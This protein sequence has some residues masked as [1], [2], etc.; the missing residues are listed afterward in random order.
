L[1]ITIMAK[2]IQVFLAHASEDKQRVREL[3]MKLEAKGFKPWLDV[4]DILPGQNWKTEIPK[5]I[6]S[7]DIFVACF[8]NA[9]VAKKGYVQSEFKLALVSYSDRPP[10][11]I[12]FVPVK[13]DD[14]EIPTLQMPEVGIDVAHFQWVE[15]SQTDGFDRLVKAIETVAD[16]YHPPGTDNA[17][18]RPFT[19]CKFEIN[20]KYTRMDRWKKRADVLV[21]L[22]DA[23]I[24]GQVY[25]I[26]SGAAPKSMGHTEILNSSP[27]ALERKR[28]ATRQFVDKFQDQ[29]VMGKSFTMSKDNARFTA[30]YS[31]TYD[32]FLTEYATLQ[33]KQQQE[34]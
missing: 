33:A 25:L 13:L 10:G 26:P 28:T 20:P 31:S 12:F 7:S 24:T 15:L 11:Q 3:H 17:R 14:C 9:S 27:E 30:V 8:S 16:V 18:E 21:D 6:H 19:P 2:P 32:R 22:H 23:K 29:Q 4:I 5:A 1:E 34:C